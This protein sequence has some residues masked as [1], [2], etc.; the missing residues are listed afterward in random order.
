MTPGPPQ[1]DDIELGE[2]IASTDLSGMPYQV[3]L[4]VEPDEEIIFA[5]RQSP[6]TP[7]AQLWPVAIGFFGWAML[8]ATSE[9]VANVP[10]AP[11]VQVG[12]LVMTALLGARWIVRDALGWYVCWYILTDR[13]LIVSRGLLRRTRYEASTARIQTIHFERSNPIANLLRIGDVQVLTASSTGAI[14]LTGV[15]KPEDVAYT[16]SLVQQG[17]LGKH[18]ARAANESP[19][20][21]DAP[22]VRAAVD[23]LLLDDDDP[24]DEQED[25]A[26]NILMGGL[27]RRSID[28]ALLPGERVLDRL[29]RHWFVL[30]LRLLPPLGIGVGVILLLAALRA[31]LGGPPVIWSIIVIAGLVTLVWDLLIVSNYIDDVFILTNQRIIDIDRQYFIFAEARRETLYRSVQDVEINIPLLGRFFGYGHLHVETAGRAPNIDMQNMGNPRA[32]QERI[33]ALINADKERRDANE[34]KSQRK[35]LHSSLETVLTALMIATPDVRGL[36]V[37]V[38]ATRLRAVGLGVTIAGERPSSQDAPGSVLS[39]TP[40]P[41]ATALRGADVALTLSRRPTRARP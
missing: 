29:Y 38:A 5:V 32:T 34:R 18:G 20:P 4:I 31:L 35:A 1:T 12:V 2:P 13:R 21:L 26:H 3:Q 11:I 8:N 24:E 40:S 15:H 27:V 37:T 22:A 19:S 25:D 6:L 30:L 23:T 16:I 17:K 14:W 39:Q 36:P 9:A 28:L 33:F 10:A 7:L 41:G